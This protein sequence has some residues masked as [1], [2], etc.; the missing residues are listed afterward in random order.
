MKQNLVLVITSLLTI[1]LMTLHLTSDTI[2][3][4]VGTPEAGGST[5]IAVPILVLWLYGTL[6]LAER[7]SG[8][9]IMLIGSIIGMGMPVFHVMGAGGIFHV[10]IA[11]SSPAFL[12]VW[13]LHALGVTGMFSFILSVRALWSLRRGQPR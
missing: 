3:A 5:L 11:R 7:R 1:L 13:T 2:H 8:Q 12:F 10:E 9:I 6:V 4:R